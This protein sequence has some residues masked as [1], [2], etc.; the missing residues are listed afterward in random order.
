M[1]RIA[2]VYS[3]LAGKTRNE[4]SQDIPEYVRATL[5]A[6]QVIVAKDASLSRRTAG[7]IQ[8]WRCPCLTAWLRAKRSEREEVLMARGTAESGP[9]GLLCYAGHLYWV[10]V[11]THRCNLLA[12]ARAYSRP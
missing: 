1:W 10:N 12:P 2:A 7:L 11:T 8:K 9:N 4:V 6:E 5:R 3:D